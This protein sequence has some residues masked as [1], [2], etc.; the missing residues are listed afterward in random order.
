MDK[1]HI[2][3]EFFVFLKC[4]FAED[5][6]PEFEI[7]GRGNQDF[8]FTWEV[9]GSYHDINHKV[10]FYELSFQSLQQILAP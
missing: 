10:E 7:F 1:N 4:G 6:A 5:E 8:E 3:V 2:F 9:L